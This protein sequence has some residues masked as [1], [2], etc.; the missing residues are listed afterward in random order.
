MNY[1]KKPSIGRIALPLIE[2][3][4]NQQSCGE[5]S[6]TDCGS[7]DNEGKELKP[8]IITLSLSGELS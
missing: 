7:Y 1:V 8:S 3:I 4:A 5:S 2:M 6:F